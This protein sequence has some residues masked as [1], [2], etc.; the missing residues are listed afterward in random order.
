MSTKQS[1][2]D[3][4]NVNDD[5]TAILKTIMTRKRIMIIDNILVANY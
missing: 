4:E 2:Y 3:D 1:E 5:T